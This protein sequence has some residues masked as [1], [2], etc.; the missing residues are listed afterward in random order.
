MQGE[1]FMKLMDLNSLKN[2][3]LR[4]NEESLFILGRI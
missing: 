4:E 3:I 1:I 2:D